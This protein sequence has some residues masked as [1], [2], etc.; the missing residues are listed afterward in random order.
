MDR[1]PRSL[2]KTILALLSFPAA[3]V[4]GL[5]FWTALPAFNDLFAAFGADLPGP[6]RWVMEHPDGVLLLLRSLLIHNLVWLIAWLCVRQ[7]W[8][9]L[10]LSLATLLV[11]LAL[12]MLV[13][14]AYLPIF[15]MSVVVS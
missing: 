14:A 4:I 1:Q 10:L 8:V 13:A 6:T 2:I 5:G 11:W 9:G 3:C 7:R 15:K 12:A